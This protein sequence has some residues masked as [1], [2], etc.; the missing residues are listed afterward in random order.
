M[1]FFYCFL[2]QQIW[3]SWSQENAF[4]THFLTSKN[5]L[6][7]ADKHHFPC[8]Y[9]GLVIKY[10][11]SHHPNWCIKVG[12]T[13]PPKKNLSCWWVILISFRNQAWQGQLVMFSLK[14][15]LS[16]I[17]L[18]PLFME[19]LWMGFNCLKATEPPR[20]DSVVLLH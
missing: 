8:E 14:I 6:S 16:K 13:S 1:S 18:R 4:L 2:Y 3:I 19:L 17:T 5:I 7:I 9:Y 11:K 10:T 12:N 15:L 20:R